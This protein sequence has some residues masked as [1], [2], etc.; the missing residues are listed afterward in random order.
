LQGHDKF[1][2]D[3]DLLALCWGDGPSAKG[4]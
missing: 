2:R 1:N 3:V 4:A